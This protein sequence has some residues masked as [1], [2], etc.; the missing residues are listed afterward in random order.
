[1]VRGLK[2]L[3]IRKILQRKVARINILENKFKACTNSVLHMKI[4]ALKRRLKKEKQQR[5][6]LEAFALGRE[7][8][9]RIL[10]LRHFDVQL[11]GGL[12]LNKSKIA[13][14]KT[15][16]GKTIVAI[17]PAFF[18]TLFGRT[19]HVITVNEYLAYRDSHYTGQVHSFLGLTIGFIYEQMRV[20]ERRKNYKCDIVYATN[21]EIGFDFLRDNIVGNLNEVVQ[22]PFYYCILDEIDSIL[23]DDANTP[24]ILAG[25]VSVKIKKVN[26][27]VYCNTTSCI[28]I[29]LKRNIHYKIDEKLRL[30]SLIRSGELICEE[31]LE[32]ENIFDV[33]S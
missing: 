27:K 16:E 29:K 15:G 18:N 8:S 4:I 17:L 30:A 14:M 2:R 25:N 13:E 22:Q 11:F 3:I 31:A 9:K 7:V 6:I 28:V 19:V 26:V 1:M 21:F 23:I 10:G 24:L 12:I 32:L 20:F 33:S 5:L